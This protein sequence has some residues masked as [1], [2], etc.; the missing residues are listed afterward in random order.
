ML[1]NITSVKNGRSLERANDNIHPRSEICDLWYSQEQR[2]SNNRNYSDWSIWEL[3][4]AR[5]QG[6]S[7]SRHCFQFSELIDSLIALTSLDLSQLAIIYLPRVRVR[8][9][10]Q[11]RDQGTVNTFLHSI[12]GQFLLKCTLLINVFS[13][14]TFCWHFMSFLPKTKSPDVLLS[15]FYG[16]DYSACNW[17][18]F[19]RIHT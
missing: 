10:F 6:V 15:S 13:M 4:S 18:F 2:R 19:S 7:S 17:I 1:V 16:V 9:S 12:F 3:G 11:S 14:V 8:P 5:I